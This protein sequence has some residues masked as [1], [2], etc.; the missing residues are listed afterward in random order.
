LWFQWFQAVNDALDRLAAFTGRRRAE[1]EATAQQLAE[2][3]TPSPAPNDTI[4]A[5]DAPDPPPGQAT[6]SDGLARLSAWVRQRVTEAEAKAAEAKRQAEERCQAEAAERAREVALQRAIEAAK[7]AVPDWPP[8]NGDYDAWVEAV[9]KPVRLEY[10]L[11]QEGFRY[12]AEPPILNDGEVRVAII[13]DLLRWAATYYPTRA[14]PP[15]DI[16]ALGLTDAEIGELFTQAPSRQAHFALVDQPAIRN[17]LTN[18]EL[19][20][21]VTATWAHEPGHDPARAG[22]P[23]GWMQAVTGGFYG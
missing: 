10:Q 5:A 22:S 8:L 4:H 12:V 13:A 17:R 15:P 11:K 1:H 7:S 19:A 20:A 9:M 18:P 6:P 23:F 3:P 14:E 16:L 21:T 2:T